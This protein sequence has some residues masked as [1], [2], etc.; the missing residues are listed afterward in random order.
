MIRDQAVKFKEQLDSLAT[1]SRLKIVVINPIFQRTSCRVTADDNLNLRRRDV[2][3]LWLVNGC[4]GLGL[5]LGLPSYRL[6]G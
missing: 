4:Y 5:R 3:V 6:L 1:R 2:V